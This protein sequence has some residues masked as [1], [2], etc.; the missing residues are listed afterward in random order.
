MAAVCKFNDNTK[1][2][3]TEMASRVEVKGED[4]TVGSSK[5][6][7]E[8][9]MSKNSLKAILTVRKIRGESRAA[10]LQAPSLPSH[11]SE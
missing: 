6:H 8:T 2:H 7:T 5:K 3:G 11:Q 1:R 4:A 9:M 10:L